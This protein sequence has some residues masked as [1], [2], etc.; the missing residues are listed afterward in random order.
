RK[1]LQQEMVNF[2]YECKEV[3]I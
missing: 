1:L 3:H 2:L